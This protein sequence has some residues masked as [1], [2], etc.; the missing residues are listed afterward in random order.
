MRGRWVF[1][2]L[3]LLA[4]VAGCLSGDGDKLAVSGTIEADDVRVSSLVGGRVAEVLADE[5]DRVE[6][7]HVLL[8]FDPADIELQAR[9]ARGVL[10]MAEAQLALAHAG[11]RPEDIASAR[12]LYNQAQTAEAA[13]Q[14]DLGRVDSLEGAG[15]V[16]GKQADDAQTRYDVSVHQTRAAKQQYNKAL[17]GARP[18]EVQMAEAGVEQAEAAVALAE[19]K[20]A[21]CEVVAP[22]SGT[23]VHRLVSPGEVSGPGATLFVVQDLDTVRLTVFVPESDV[24]AVR[25][26]DPVAVS[27]DSHPDR[28][29]P[30][31]VSR[32]RDEAEF[33]PKNVQTK[34]ERVKLVFGVEVELDNPDGYLKPGLPADAVIGSS[35]TTVAEVG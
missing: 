24:G 21:D 13:A 2:G 28:T 27:I 3:G 1:S 18:E 10:H 20:L 8:R 30:G 31:R 29:F 12:E 9:Q 5:G 17:R 35:S 22:L 4:L 34:D 7:G 26:G 15:G 11:A 33:T 23:V 32:I 14:A 6:A 16:T 25:L 19:K